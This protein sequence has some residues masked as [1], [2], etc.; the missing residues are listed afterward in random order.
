[1]AYYLKW[2]SFHNG[3]KENPE[4]RFC[5]SGCVHYQTFRENAGRRHLC[6]RCGTEPDLVLRL[7]YREKREVL[8]IRRHGNHGIFHS[9]GYGCQNSRDGQAGHCRMRRRIF[10]DVYDGTGHHQTASDPG[11]D[12]CIEK[13]LSR[14]G[15]R[16]SALYLQRSLFCGRSVGK[17]RSGEI[18][19]SLWYSLSA[20]E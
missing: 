4:S 14:Y 10:P 7:S 20:F 15:S 9:C 11:Q 6:R 3:E 18:I 17:S 13:Q 19:R 12:H 1:M 2:V 16:I 5:R 8:N